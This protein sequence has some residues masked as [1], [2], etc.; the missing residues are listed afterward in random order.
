MP[1]TSTADALLAARRQR[2]VDTQLRERGI[3]NPRVLAAMARVPRHEFVDAAF[4]DQ[5]YDDTPLPIG[6]GQTISQ[7]YMV[8]I[9]LELLD[10]RAEDMVLE[11]GTGSGYQAALLAEL[12]HHVDSIERHPA[13]A[14][15]AERVLEQLGYANV[16][17]HVGDG[18]LGLASRS[19]FDAI[20]VGAAAPQVPP[21]L[22]E[23]LNE[24]GRLAVPVG[25]ADA[26]LLHV[27]TRQPGKAVT[28]ETVGCRFVPLIGEQ[29]Y[30]S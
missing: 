3:R 17:I 1:A 10:P 24:G 30:R 11:V 2:M 16:A 9:M 8:A 26:Q 21:A 15:R 23:Q 25:P 29:G 12:S 5:A 18:S 14:A 19:P 13:L 7:P 20:I 22:L 4:R 28:S 27:V 6:D